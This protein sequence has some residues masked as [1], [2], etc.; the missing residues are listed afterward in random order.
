[1]KKEVWMD[2]VGDITTEGYEAIEEKL[3]KEYGITLTTE[4]SVK[5]WDS[6]W[7]FVENFSNGNYR[8]EM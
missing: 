6:I 2:D 8:H 1:M 4:Q 3:E 5:L 7:L